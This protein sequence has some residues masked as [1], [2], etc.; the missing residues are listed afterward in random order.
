MYYELLLFVFLYF[1]CKVELD[2]RVG[3]DGVKGMIWLYCVYVL[4]ITFFFF[5]FM[6]LKK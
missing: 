6:F 3:V 1:L 5:I 4:F 2:G